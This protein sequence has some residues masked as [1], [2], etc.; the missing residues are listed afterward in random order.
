[1]N[2][3]RIIYK[4]IK[5]YKFKEDIDPFFQTIIEALYE[6]TSGNKL[7]VNE[8]IFQKI[9]KSY[10]NKNIVLAFINTIKSSNYFNDNE[11]E[12]MINEL[13]KRG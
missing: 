3:A 13:T 8:E 6:Y 1:M 10:I 5:Q 2:E 9:M 11:K 4:D 12:K 7:I